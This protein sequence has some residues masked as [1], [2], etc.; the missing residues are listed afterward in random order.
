MN[1][2]ISP[3]CVS[4]GGYMQ[5]VANRSNLT[6]DQLPNATSCVKTHWQVGLFRRSNVSIFCSL[7]EFDLSLFHTASGNTRPSAP[8]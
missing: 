6:L 2:N 1:R 5:I 4:V 7:S 3:E 8:A